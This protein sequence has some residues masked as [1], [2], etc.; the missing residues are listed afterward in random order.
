MGMKV[1][2]LN[3]YRSRLTIQ[4]LEALLEKAKAGQLVGLAACYK[5]KDGKEESVIAGAYGRNP[6]AAAS[7]ALRLSMQLAGARGEYESV[8]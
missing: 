1:V 6:D 4:V 7:S 8:L 5:C 2:S 3:S